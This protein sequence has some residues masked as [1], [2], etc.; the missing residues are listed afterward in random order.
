MKALEPILFYA[1]CAFSRLS[2]TQHTGS[3]SRLGSLAA[4]F[5][6]S[7]PSCEKIPYSCAAYKR[8]TATLTGDG[9]G[10]HGAQNTD[11]Q[12]HLL[13]PPSMPPPHH[14]NPVFT[15]GDKSIVHHQG[16]PQLQTPWKIRLCR[17]AIRSRRSVARSHSR[18]GS[19]RSE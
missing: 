17:A 1:F 10:H 9:I 14:S 11:L 8:E 3:F 15:D 4:P 6:F 16:W 2:L 12:I 13:P 18:G 5:V 19:G 7:V